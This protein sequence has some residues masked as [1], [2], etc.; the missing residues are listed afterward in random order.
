MPGDSC[1][2][3]GNSRKK[4][5]KLSYHRFP[6][7]QAKRSQWLRVFQLDP[8]VVKPHTRVCSRHF[9]NG[10]P[11]NDRQ[12]KIGRRFAS[13]IK[14]ESDRTTRAIERQR[15][16]RNLEVQSLLTAS[17]SASESSTSSSRVLCSS[18]T[19][20]DHLL[21]V[22]ESPAEAMERDEEP[23]TALV[24]EQLLGDYQV[25]DLPDNGS[26]AQASSAADQPLVTTAL[27][28]RIEFLEA[29]CSRLQNSA[30]KILRFGID[31][32]KHDDC[33]VSFYTGF[34]SFAIFLA[35]FQFLGP[36]VDKLQYWGGKQSAKKR[37]RAKKLTPMDQLFMTLVKLRLDLKVVDIAFRFNISTAL[38]SRYFTTWICFLY[39]HLKE[40]DWMPS[41]KQVE[42][43][44]PTAFREKYPSTYCIIDGSEIFMETPSDLHMQLSTWSSYKHHN[45]AKFLTGCTPNGCV[46]FISPL[47]VGS[48]SDV[49]LTRV[50]GL[51]NCIEDKPGILIMADRG[52]TIKDMLDNIGVKLNIP[53]FMEGRKQLPASEVREGRKIASVRIHVE[54]AIGRIKSFQILKHT[55]PITLAGLSNQ[56]VTVC[57]FLSNFK[58]V[59]VPPAEP[60]AEDE[61][62][63]GSDV[64]DYFAE[65]SESEDSKEE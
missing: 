11:I 8:E 47:Y 40:I 50:S 27:L 55:I 4:A 60:Y 61:F 23:M 53:P 32:I 21:A 16:K 59:L 24:G 64:E 2:V 17:S 12:A 20:D 3:C 35:F 6:T 44:L 48:I 54:R 30:S 58:P 39:H 38:V 5:P 57:A 22:T 42:G 28:A 49:E 46:S 1:V 51:L 13:P 25:I 31:Q 29:E 43:T 26:T 9:M 10:D 36:V 14:K 52:F 45:T 37:Q 63:S 19:S 62:D 56:I 65:L 7:N 34:P 18:N 41:V 33:L 15:T